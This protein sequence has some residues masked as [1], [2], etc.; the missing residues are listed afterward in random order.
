MAVRELVV[1]LGGEPAGVLVRSSRG[2]LRFEYG[3]GWL[4]SPGRYPL[5]VSMP[6]AGAFYT[7][8][9]VRPFVDNLLPDDLGWRA[10]I[11]KH[12]RVSAADPFAL[13]SHVGEDCAGA[14]Q[15]V[16]PERLEQMRGQAG[17]EDLEWLS[18]EEIG[19][20]LRARVAGRKNGLGP[21]EYIGYFSLPGA[22][23]KMVL[24]R[25]GDRWARAR[26]AAA[27]THILKPPAMDEYP[28]LEYNEHFCLR[29]AAAVGFDVARSEVMAFDGIKAIVVE[30]Y[31]REE[32][33]GCTV[34][35]HQ[36]DLCQALSVDPNLKY[37]VDGGPGVARLV[38][39]IAQEASDVDALTF[40]DALIFNWVILGTD[41]HAK[42]Y[43]F[44]IRPGPRIDLAPL[45]DVISLLAKA[46]KPV[47]RGK[48]R[49]S[50]RVGGEYQAGRM[51][52]RKWRALETQI[53]VDPGTLV[54]RARWKVEQV[55]AAVG[56]VAEQIREEGVT[57]PVIDHLEAGVHTHGEACLVRLREAEPD[58]VAE[59][60]V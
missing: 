10:A 33:D 36:E 31:D 18:E 9:V 6:L 39:L 34:R 35:I 51:R 58:A 25:R 8:R 26:G 20:E 21:R 38:S 47:E 13:L 60:L 23:P 3:A 2:D 52:A 41:A 11:G 53:G 59:A 12:F 14:V 15:F 44:L 54:A 27:S 45:Y 22:Q 42:N 7:D 24:V 50:M 46:R 49:M 40:L 43:S 32:I 19:E 37:E 5:S 16:Q 30:R 29:L 28:G 1:L 56:E 48:I 57:H 17:A 4:A 55:V